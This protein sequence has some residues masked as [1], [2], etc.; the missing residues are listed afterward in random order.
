[1]FRTYVLKKGKIKMTGSAAKVIDSER[2]QIV[3]THT[4][5]RS[6]LAGQKA[7]GVMILAAA[8]AGVIAGSSFSALLVLSPLALA[9]V[10]SKEK[11]MD[12][13]IFGSQSRE[14]QM[15]DF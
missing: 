13:R 14:K 7:A 5:K 11:I 6:S 15:R 9:A 12:F 8:A 10:F 1:M 3:M 2:K 4:V